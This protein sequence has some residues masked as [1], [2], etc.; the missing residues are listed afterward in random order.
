M[1]IQW[2]WI[3]IFSKKFAV[4][5]FIAYSSCNWTA[6]FVKH[7]CKTFF[8]TGIQELQSDPVTNHK[9]ESAS[10]EHWEEV[11]R[12]DFNNQERSRQEEQQAA[13]GCSAPNN[14]QFALGLW[15]LVQYQPNQSIFPLRARLGTGQPFTMGTAWSLCSSAGRGGW[16]SALPGSQKKA[17]QCPHRRDLCSVPVRG[18]F[19][20]AIQGIS[21]AQPS[22]HLHPGSSPSSLQG[23]GFVGFILSV[24]STNL[25]CCTHRA[26]GSVLPLAAKTPNLPCG[27]FFLLPFPG[28][29]SILGS[30]QNG[31]GT[32][33]V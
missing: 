29:Y 33:L 20:V 23:H 7:F 30:I 11:Y 22:S 14:V 10:Y 16:H 15:N 5:D 26:V 12:K 25:I 6:A 9:Q 28:S 21:A 31:W 27:S 17:W 32:L 3:K 24:C 19:S 13:E 18:C 4:R 2:N 1:L 8:K